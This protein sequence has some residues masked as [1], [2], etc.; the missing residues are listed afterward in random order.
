MLTGGGGPVGPMFTEG[1]RTV[2]PL[3]TGGGLVGPLLT[4][5]GGPVGPMF[6]EGEST[7]KL[8]LT[9]EWPSDHCSLEE[10]PSN[11]CSLKERG[12]SNHYSLEE[13]PSDHRSQRVR[14][15]SGHCS[16]EKDP[17]DHCSLEKGPSDYCPSDHCSLEER[18]PSN[19]CS[20]IGLKLQVYILRALFSWGGV[21]LELKLVR[22]R[23]PSH[24]ELDG[25]CCD[26]FCWD[27]CD[28]RFVI[29]VHRT[30]STMS[31]SHC[32][33]KKVQTGVIYASDDDFNF[34]STLPSNIANP[35]VF[36]IA[37]WQGGVRIKIDVWM[38]DNNADDHIDFYARNININP[39][40]TESTANFLS[41]T[42]TGQGT[43]ET[44]IQLKAYCQ[45][46][47]YGSNC[48]TYCVPRDSDSSGHYTC[49][50]RTGAKICRPG[51]RGALC[52]ININECESTPC[53]NGG[54]C[55]DG[56]NSFSCT[57]LAGTSGNLCQ[58]N[59]DDCASQP[60][61]H[62]ATCVD[63][64]NGYQC[65]CQVGYTGR[66][67]EIDVDEC[68][69]NPCQNRATCLDQVDGYFCECSPGLKELLVT[70]RL[71]NALVVPVV[72]ARLAPMV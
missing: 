49:N 21:T 70:S 30:G 62:Q 13:G 47:Y 59:F 14:E 31:T 24:N 44:N 68:S 48:N 1:E 29:C 25:G 12:P 22:Y 71:T 40:R 20:R 60:C 41:Y 23:N 39:A 16:I 4:R 35:I 58:M 54:E 56:R 67:C 55:T 42:L 43:S 32:T 51:Y 37:S 52:K 19:H 9:G 50:S 57:C 10:G 18:Y 27:H 63:Q 46:N 2:R 26:L 72:M 38:E 33:Y 45:S 34:P 61:Q 6:N 66:T 65:L 3:F 5:G 11:Q 69:S 7:V 36:D 15:P 53:Q 17:S 8:L 64:I 28:N